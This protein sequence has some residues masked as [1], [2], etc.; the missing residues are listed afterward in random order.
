MSDYTAAYV[1]ILFMLFQIGAR[2]LALVV[3]APAPVNSIPWWVS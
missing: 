3:G 2:G 1:M